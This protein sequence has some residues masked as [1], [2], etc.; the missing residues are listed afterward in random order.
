MTEMDLAQERVE[1]SQGRE[2][3]YRSVDPLDDSFRGWLQQRLGG[4]LSPRSVI[5][6]EREKEAPSETTRMEEDQSTTGQRAAEEVRTYVA[7]TA[8]EDLLD[9]GISCG[10]TS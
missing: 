4:S 1:S 2:V 7:V 3:R 6:F 9:P 10:R 8:A 5:W